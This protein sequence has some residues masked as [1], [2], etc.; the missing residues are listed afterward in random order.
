M[1]CVQEYFS[2]LAFY[3]YYTACLYIFCVEIE[4]RFVG[5]VQ[6]PFLC[7]LEVGD[8]ES[9]YWLNILWAC[10]FCIVEA[11]V[12][13]ACCSGSFWGSYSVLQFPV[14]WSVGAH[15][16]LSAMIGRYLS[17]PLLVCYSMPCSRRCF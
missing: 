2:V 14:L 10:C 15:N 8:L 6:A 5:F 7:F 1:L 17:S 4:I 13:S 9:S 11:K 16:V 12:S 3:N